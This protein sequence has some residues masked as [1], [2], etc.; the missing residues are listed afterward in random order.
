M[1]VISTSI[2]GRPTLGA[3]ACSLLCALLWVLLLAPSGA[4]LQAQSL[5]TGS[6]SYHSSGVSADGKTY[7]WGVNWYG[8]LGNGS[9]TNANV[10][11]DISARIGKAVVSVAN[12]YA[13]TLALASDGTVYAWGHGGSGQ[14]GNG[15]NSIS[16]VPVQVSNLTGVTAIA[17]GGW[18]S[19]AVGANGEVYTW[20]FGGSGQLGNGG[21]SNSNLPVQVS[22][23][24]GVTAIAAGGYHSMAIGANGEVYAWGHGYQGQLG[25]G[26]GGSSLLPV[27]V[28]N[29]TGVTA[30]AAGAYHSMAIGANGEVYAWGYGYQ[31]QLGN[32][33]I[34]YSSLLPVQVSNLTGVKAI[35]AGMHHSMAIGAGGEVYAWGY[36]GNGEL[37]NGTY[38]LSSIPVQVKDP[39]GTGLLTGVKAIA[40]GIYHSLAIGA[41]NQAYAW[42]FGYWGQ[43][44]N[45][46]NSRSPLPVP[47]QGLFPASCISPT[48]VAQNISRSLDASGTATVTPADIDNGSGDGCGSVTMQVASTFGTVCATAQEGHNLTLQA[49]AGTVIVAINFASYGTP[50]GSCGAFS[51]GSCHAANSKSIVEGLA[52][53]KSSVTIPATNDVFGDPCVGTV[54][55]LYVTATYAAPANSISYNCT[56]V[57]N[58]PV[59]LIVTDELGNS[60]TATATVT[61]SDASAPTFT[62]ATPAEASA[63]NR[64]TSQGCTYVAQ[65]TE[66]DAFADDNCGVTS[67]TYALSGATTATA[68]EAT[69]LAGVAFNEGTSTVTWT[70]VDAVGN[71]TSR[72]F[73]VTVTNQLP[74]PSA[75]TPSTVEP[76][77]INTSVS[78]TA[79]FTDNNV[80]S[81]TWVWGDGTETVIGP[82][83]PAIALAAGTIS[84]SHTYTTPGV[85]TVSLTL[86][87]ACDESVTSTYEYAVVYDPYGGF[88]TG[89]GW[90]ISPAGAYKADV[91][92]E[93]RANF[94]FVSKYK[95]GATVPSG[96]TNFQFQV[97]NLHFTSTSYEWLVVSGATARY[98]GEGTINGSGWYGFILSAID[99]QVSGGG[100]TDKFRIKIWDKNNGDVVVYDNNL[101]D[102]GDDAYAELAIAGGSIVVHEGT[103]T[104]SSSSLVAAGAIAPEQLKGS[105]Y[106][107]PTAFSDRTTIAFSL[108]KEESYV[109]EVYDMKGAL[110]KRMANG[111]AEAD[112]L[113][114]FELRSDNLREGIYIARLTTASSVQSLK[115]VLKR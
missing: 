17:A 20:G 96:H 98:K 110:V 106:S 71:S 9:T 54:K 74:D 5:G 23:L 83:S 72:S 16:Y 92:L 2:N 56:N 85:Y 22:N 43:L 75:I 93:G 109:L 69:S 13:H 24:T 81:A 57:G 4:S 80:V 27:Q 63:F 82:T 111:S 50:E 88:V 49:P 8:Q 15:T 84:G 41:D 39:A 73:S 44:G 31:G 91:T 102:T 61:V 10:P 99:G 55:R 11:Q 60:Q 113:Y 36:G 104:S 114:E 7:T 6:F 21:T 89:G 67:L 68:T 94:G 66:F 53:G 107:Y 34:T 77:Q 65:G 101:G 51:I 108:E 87:D 48:P 29:L 19:M 100:G 70:A 38:T 1:K 40:A 64:G 97:A 90:I 95:K 18:H 62:A 14:L 35:A 25:N 103:R 105:F 30:I 33:T 46:T 45:G 3:R 32:G 42:G 76:I 78:A 47:V 112:R 12:G 115:A 59:M 58:N 86:T 26:T 28:S 79:S 52:L 37:G